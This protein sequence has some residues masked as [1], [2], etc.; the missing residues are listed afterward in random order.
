MWACDAEAHLL[1]SAEASTPAPGGLIDSHVSA[2]RS[3]ALRWERRVIPTA[4][5]YLNPAELALSGPAGFGVFGL[6]RCAPRATGRRGRPNIR[7]PSPFQL[8]AG[9]QA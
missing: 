8:S 6:W 3:E 2:F 5:Q 9:R 1:G 7:S 4:A